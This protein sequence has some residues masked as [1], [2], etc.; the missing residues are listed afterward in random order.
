MCVCEKRLV[1][2]RVNG[3]LEGEEK[4]MGK[5]WP[6]VRLKDHEL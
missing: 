1:G 6:C 4:A 3:K 5:G 2:Q